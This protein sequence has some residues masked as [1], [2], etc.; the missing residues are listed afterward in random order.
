MGLRL[1]IYNYPPVHTSWVEKRWVP[2]WMLTLKPKFTFLEARDTWA[3]GYMLMV[4]FGSTLQDLHFHIRNNN[5][6]GMSNWT[7]GTLCQE[8]T[9][10][11]PC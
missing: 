4:R 9:G 7:L 10:F 8:Q 11:K 1:D 2:E 5:R 6:N 3:L